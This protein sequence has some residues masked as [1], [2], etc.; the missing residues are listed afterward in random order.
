MKID[1]PLFVKLLKEKIDAKQIS[2]EKAMMYRNM[3]ST[4]ANPKCPVKMVGVLAKQVNDFIG[5]D[6]VR[7]E[8]L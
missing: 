3:L 7:H 5:K 6:I 2:K 4:L 8:I 1:Y